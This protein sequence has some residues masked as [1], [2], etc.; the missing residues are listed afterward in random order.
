[1]QDW[2]R[3]RGEAARAGAAARRRWCGIPAPGTG[4]PG[5]AGPAK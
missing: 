1:L 4:R 2:L 3:K 5:Q